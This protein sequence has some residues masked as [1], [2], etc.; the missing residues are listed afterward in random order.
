[1]LVAVWLQ[2]EGTSTFACSKTISPFSFAMLAARKSHEISSKGCRPS[3]VK[4]RGT[5]RPGFPS[6]RRFRALSDE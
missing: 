3:S 5:F 2:K 6:V 4:K 1:M